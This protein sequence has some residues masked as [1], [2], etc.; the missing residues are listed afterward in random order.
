MGWQKL[1][2]CQPLHLLSSLLSLFLGYVPLSIKKQLF[3]VIILGP[4][5]GDGMMCLKCHTVS[6]ERFFQL[7]TSLKLGPP[8]ACRPRMWLGGFS[9]SGRRFVWELW[10]GAL[11]QDSAALLWVSQEL[12]EAER[13]V[14][15]EPRWR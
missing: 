8:Q 14:W 13:C 9:C 6:S 11:G 3:G 15:R 7:G 2:N 5:R 10:P 1:C 4:V 12:M